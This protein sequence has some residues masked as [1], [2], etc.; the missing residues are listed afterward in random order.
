LPF[1]SKTIKTQLKVEL[2]EDKTN[3]SGEEMSGNVR[4]MFCKMSETDV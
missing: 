2:K 4:Q 1:E 3:V